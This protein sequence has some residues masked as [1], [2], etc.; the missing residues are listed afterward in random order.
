MGDGKENLLGA[1]QY[2]TASGPAARITAELHRRGMPVNAGGAPKQSLE[3]QIALPSLLQ[4]ADVLSVI[5]RNF[6]D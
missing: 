4:L 1:K 6:C 5:D 3:S 2:G